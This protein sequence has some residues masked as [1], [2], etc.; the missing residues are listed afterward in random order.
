M[1]GMK[2]ALL[3]REAI[4]RNEITKENEKVCLRRS[5]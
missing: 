5:H 3:D 2:K 1:K 4:H